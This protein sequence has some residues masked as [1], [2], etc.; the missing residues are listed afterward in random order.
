M[1]PLDER[2]RRS[3]QSLADKVDRAELRLMARGLP[4]DGA[5]VRPVL[6]SRALAFGGA[7]A[8]IMMAIGLAV[9][10]MSGE[11]AVVTES[12]PETAT[13]IPATTT[14]PPQTAPETTPTAS[15]TTAAPTTAAQEPGSDSTPPPLEITSPQQ[16][17]EV[18]SSAVT[19]QGMTEPGASVTRGRFSADV[20]AE[21]NWSIVLIVGEGTSNVTFTATDEAGNESQASV[22]VSYTPPDEEEKETP[23]VYEFTAS[24]TYG[25]CAETP[26]YD[27]YHGT[28]APGATVTIS[29]E[30][31]GGSTV[32]NSEGRW[33]KQVFFP[34]APYGVPFAVKVEDD[35]GQQKTFEFVS[36]AG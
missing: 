2:A 20:D 1:N 10:Q 34:S 9:V 36:Y 3:A 25:E 28:A 6:A 15:P 23:P 16:G 12:P 14:P 21:G 33:E 4:A 5:S 18:P 17:E 11:G 24:A 7:A 22:E 26:P 27:V 32:A 13:E 31:G 30:Y 35:S 19:F 29:S 8:V